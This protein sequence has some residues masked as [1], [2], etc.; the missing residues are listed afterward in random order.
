M[1]TEN[2]AW[3]ALAVNLAVL[4]GLGTLFLGRYA[5]GLVQI[6][7]SGYGVV[8]LVRWL[9]AFVREWSRL[10]SFPLDRGP[11]FPHALLGLALVV[12]SWVWCARSGW[13]IARAARSA[14]RG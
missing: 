9:L 10:G 5:A 4:P 14:P 6:A 13:A 1:T 12:T 8:A 11:L 2:R 7:L 3:V